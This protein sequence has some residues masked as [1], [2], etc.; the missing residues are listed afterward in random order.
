MTK[1]KEPETQTELLKYR[2]EP[3]KA[4]ELAI[5]MEL[6]MQNQHQNQTH[7]KTYGAES[8]NSIQYTA[9]ACSV[10]W[11]T[12]NYFPKRFTQPPAFHCQICCL[13]CIPGQ[14]TNVLHLVTHAITVD[15]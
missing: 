3:W 12:T 10:T 6:G 11:S 2:L 15:Y 8:V 13:V 7:D 1:V 14:K 4:L 5:N 9:S